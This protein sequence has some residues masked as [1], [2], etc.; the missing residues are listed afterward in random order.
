MQPPA[1]GP[2]EGQNLEV[3]GL[4]PRDTPSASELPPAVGTRA[5][6]MLLVLPQPPLRA[7]GI[8][9]TVW[10]P[11][12]PG[13]LRAVGGG[14]RGWTLSPQSGVA[15]PPW[16]LPSQWVEKQLHTVDG[17]PPHPHPRPLPQ[18]PP[19]PPHKPLWRPRPGAQTGQPRRRAGLHWGLD[20]LVSS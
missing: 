15:L 3:L 16:L 17:G 14:G 12:R 2:N 7:P 11:L 9:V 19:F 18:R 6:A 8:P 5:S 10:A 13:V 1:K 20:S 4:C